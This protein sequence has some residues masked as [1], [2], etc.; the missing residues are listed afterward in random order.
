[1]HRLRNIPIF[2]VGTLFAIGLS[3][4]LNLRGIDAPTSTIIGL[5]AVVVSLLLEV[6][7]R[8]ARMETRLWSAMGLG[9][10]LA[11]DGTLLSAVLSISNDYNSVVSSTDQLFVL[12]AK[13]LL[14]ECSNGLH[15]LAEGRMVLP[16]LSQFSF[17]LRGL[18]SVDY[19]IMSTSYVDI[20]HFWN[21]VAGERYFGKNADLATRGVAITRVFIGDRHELAKLRPTISR[22][23]EAGM[24]VYVALT[25]ETSEE[26]CEDF[27]VADERL[28]VSLQLTRD[29]RARYER[30]SVNPQEVRRSISNFDRL[31]ASAHDYDQL[32]PTT[33]QGDSGGSVGT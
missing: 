28:V 6:I 26:L 32:F 16:P 33:A 7:A 10:E 5:V 22:H 1:M 9:G 11:R 18:S 19:S 13:Y 20:A 17:G 3:L 12:R 30:I 14:D 21:S 4:F 25:D 15:E 24:T 8:M 27:L 29:G 31:V 2:L 23:R